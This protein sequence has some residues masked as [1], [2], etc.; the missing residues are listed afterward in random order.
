MTDTR[1]Y[2]PR[3]PW[4]PEARAAATEKRRLRQANHDSAS[5]GVIRT[6]RKSGLSWRAVA[7]ELTAAGIPP[8]RRGR[9]DYRGTIHGDLLAPWHPEMV[10]RIARRLGID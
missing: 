4:P 6:C 2:P 5:A 7:R 3:P 8:P 10:R 9:V 1:D